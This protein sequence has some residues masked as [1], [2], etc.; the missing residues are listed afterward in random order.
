MK[1]SSWKL[2]CKLCA[3]THKITTPIITQLF[4]N[5]ARCLLLQ[6][7]LTKGS[8]TDNKGT[9]ELFLG[10]RKFGSLHSC[11]NCFPKIQR[12]PNRYIHTIPDEKVTASWRT[13]DTHDQQ[14]ST[15]LPAF[16]YH[17]A[18]QHNL[19]MQSVHSTALFINKTNVKLKFTNKRPVTAEW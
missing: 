3:L 18:W 7:P 10:P 14:C 15:G 9:I 1:K 12:C 8:Y 19:V 11:L 4:R 2:S 6:G 5:A 13:L 16:P 17:C